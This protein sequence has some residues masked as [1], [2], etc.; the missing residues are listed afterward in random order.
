MAITVLKHEPKRACSHCNTYERV[1][2]TQCISL[3]EDIEKVLFSYQCAN[4]NGLNHVTFG[5]EKVEVVD[6]D[7]KPY[8]DAEIIEK[9]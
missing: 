7:G 6:A 4:C 1:E 3:N 2:G 9:L 5:I 8:Q